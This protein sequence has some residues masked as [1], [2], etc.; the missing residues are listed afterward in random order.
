VVLAAA[1]L[2][3]M[4]SG[5][6]VAQEAPKEA[7][8]LLEADR[9]VELAFFNIE[10]GKEPDLMGNYLPNIMPLAA[11]Y[12]GEL[13][14]VFNVTAAI[15]GVVRPQA[16]GVFTWDDLE[17]RET[18]LKDP[19]A[20]KLFPIRDNAL[21]FFKLAYFTVS[22]DTVL[23]LRSDRVYE[24]FSAWTSA[25]SQTSL[26]EFQ[27]TTAEVQER[28]GSPRTIAELIPHPYRRDLALDHMMHPDIA[29][30]VEWANTGAYYAMMTDPE[31]VEQKPVL[32]ASLEATEVLH[33]QFAFPP[34]E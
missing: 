2:L 33:M 34:A 31:Y 18:F 9:V 21:T 7:K 4:F 29:G 13:L 8:I 14:G 32:D 10:G 25:T 11:E 26:S 12:G 27:E 3:G 15:E 5:G 23:T 28:Y 6:V 24:F 19:E 1:V 16:V 22:E 30:I 20:I 17:V